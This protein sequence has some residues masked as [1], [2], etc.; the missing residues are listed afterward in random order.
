MTMAFN[1]DISNRITKIMGTYLLKGYT[2]LDSH[3]QTCQTPLMKAKSSE[4]YCIYCNEINTH[5]THNNSKNTKS[6]IESNVAMIEDIKENSS[7]TSHTR[8]NDKTIDSF[9]V[10]TDTSED[11]QRTIGVVSQKMVWAA[12]GLKTCDQISEC[13]QILNFLKMSADLLLSLN[14]LNRNTDQ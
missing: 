1:S 3:C 2:L 9:K 11:I 14:K 13:S 12:D 7:K 6:S 4:L 5:P 10:N 8:P